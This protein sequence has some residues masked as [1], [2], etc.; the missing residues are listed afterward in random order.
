MLTAEPVQAAGCRRLIKAAQAANKSKG[1]ALIGDRLLAPP[2]ATSF[3]G[4]R[5]GGRSTPEEE[6]RLQQGS[7]VF[8]ARVLR[9]SRPR[10]H[11]RADGRRAAGHDDGAAAGGIAARAGRIATT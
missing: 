2:A 1:V 10:R 7:D 4:G 5:R 3:G 8:G 11:G 6:K 9:V